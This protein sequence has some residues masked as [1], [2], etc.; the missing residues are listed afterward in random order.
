MAYLH[1]VYRI[2]NTNYANDLKGTGAYLVGGRWNT[3]GKFMLYASSSVSLCMMEVLAHVTPNTWPDNLSLV[4]INIPTNSV[5][6]LRPEDLP[7]G[8]KDLPVS[9]SAQRVGDNW[10]MSL[11]SLVLI[12]PS[13]VNFLEYNYLINPAHPLF[14]KVFVE[15]VRPWAFDPRLNHS[16]RI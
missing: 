1:K 7:I 6:I 5:K 16:N 9:S 4:T 14:K 13:V 3:V 2:A 8:W 11:E 15:D 10:I 12:V